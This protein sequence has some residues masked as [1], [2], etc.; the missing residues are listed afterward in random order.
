MRN[1]I[2]L[3][4]LVGILSVGV[5]STASASQKVAEQK[6]KVAAAKAAQKEQNARVIE[7]GQIRS[8]LNKIKLYSALDSYNEGVV[9]T[10]ISKMNNSQLVDFSKN[11]RRLA[12]LNTSVIDF[13]I[14]KGFKHT[15][16][17]EYARN[18]SE[19]LL[20]MAG[21][22]DA[23]VSVPAPAVEA[24]PAATPEAAPAK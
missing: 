2:L 20:K 21:V 1:S 12:E 11:V 17:I 3:N 13:R 23:R 8:K 9:T 19:F 4:V 10:A 22:A 6:A 7:M 14:S 24:A 15:R 16:T 18:W 5:V